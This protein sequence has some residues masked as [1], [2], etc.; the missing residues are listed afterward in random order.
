MK[1]VVVVGTPRSGTQRIHSAF[2]HAKTVQSGWETDGEDVTLSFFMAADADLDDYVFHQ[3]HEPWWNRHVD[4]VWHQTRD[5]LYCIPALAAVTPASILAWQARY[6]GLHPENYRS[7][8]EF[9]ALFWVTWNE[10]CEKRCPI[11]QYRVEDFEAV[12][13]EMWKRLDA[14]EAPPLTDRSAVLDRQI[15]EPISYEEIR[16]WGPTIYD[17]VRRLAERYGYEETE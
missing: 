9:C 17:K 13:P 4:E 10:L 11:W 7:R 8:Q 16:S 12:W 14:G 15:R 6:T 5:P 2:G 1:N 3:R